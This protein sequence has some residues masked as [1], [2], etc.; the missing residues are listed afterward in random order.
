MTVAGDDFKFRPITRADFPFIQ[1]WLAEPHVK[2]W[3]HDDL[4]ENGIES[5]YGPRADGTEPT[6]VYI[7]LENTNPIGLIQWYLWSDYP[8]HAAQLGADQRAAG[9]D[10]A[11]GEKGSVGRGIGSAVITE[12]VRQI[13]FTASS[14]NA[15]I[16]D[17]EQQNSRSLRAFEKAGFTTTGTAQLKGEDFKR[18]IVCLKRFKDESS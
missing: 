12:F 3:W 1:K 7:I 14:A 17:P 16:T 5:K 6:H 18:S 8:A 15:V 10:L 11:I 9:M 2:E 4:D 13:I